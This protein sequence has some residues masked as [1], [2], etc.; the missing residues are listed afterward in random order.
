MYS[1]NRGRVEMLIKIIYLYSKYVLILC[2]VLT[3]L[4]YNNIIVIRSSY[5][6]DFISLHTEHD[7]FYIMNV[8]NHPISV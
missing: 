5:L 4:H 3:S 6:C 7:R 2:S 8:S 1:G